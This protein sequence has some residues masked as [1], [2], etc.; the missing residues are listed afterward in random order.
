M[1]LIHYL[2][3]LF[4]S[5]LS[6]CAGVVG[7]IFLAIWTTLGDDA[8]LR[9][10]VVLYKT[11]L[12]LI[13]VAFAFFLYYWRYHNTERDIKR[14]WKNRTSEFK[15]F[16]I[17]FPSTIVFFYFFTVIMIFVSLGISQWIIAQASIFMK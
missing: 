1:K 8:T 13:L 6:L 4:L 9:N 17:L 11:S 7:S 10:S 16:V 5:I 2:P 12:I 14:Y 15:I 3:I